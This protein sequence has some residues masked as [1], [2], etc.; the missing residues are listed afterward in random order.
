MGVILEIKAGAAAGK[1]IA[2]K[3]GESVTV[4]RAGGQAQFVVAQ[5]TSMSRLHFAVECTRQGIRVAD[6]GS[7]NGTYLNGRKIQEATLLTSGDEIKAGQTVFAV[8]LISDEKLAAMGLP[9]P[10]AASPKPP[11]PQVVPQERPADRSSPIQREPPSERPPEA[12]RA[13]RPEREADLRARVEPEP[14]RP[15]TPPSRHLEEPRPP[16]P[17]EYREP[18]LAPIAEEPPQFRSIPSPPQPSPEPRAPEPAAKFPVSPRQPLRDEFGARAHDRGVRA[19]E[20]AFRVMGWSFPMAPAQW[21]VQ[22]G[23]GLRQ[24]GNAEFPASVAVSEE[25]LGGMTLQQFVEAQIGTLRGYFRDAKIEPTMPPRIGGAEESMAV[26]VR[27]STKDGKE[28]VHRWIY[29]RSGSSVGMLTVTALAA[30]LSSVLESLQTFLEGAEFR[31]T[32][33]V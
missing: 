15:P 24:T 32:V 25:V 31:S 20:A 9:G 29:A 27:H 4:G 6:R 10:A 26:D 11:V 30:E 13:P 3:T 18:P 17:Q 23:F 28:L 1:V 12:F 22:E 33:Q 7:S 19:R 8:K 2:L 21:E 16:R 5:D 14:P